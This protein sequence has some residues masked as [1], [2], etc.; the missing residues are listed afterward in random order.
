MAGS[1][2]KP[3]RIS[4][5]GKIEAEEDPLVELARIVSEDGGF[6]TPKPEK[7]RM[8]RNESPQR[9]SY[10]EDLEAE[11]LQELESSLT[12]REPP[13]PIQPRAAAPRPAPASAPRP[14]A[15]QPVRAS[16]GER[17]PD[18][19]LRSIEEQLGQFERR[20]AERVTGGSAGFAAQS[21]QPAAEEPYEE[22][23]SDEAPEEAFDA[24]EEPMPA[25]PSRDTWQS[26]VSR[27]RPLDDDE[28]GGA[29]SEPAWEPEPV[30]VARSDYRFRGPASADWDRPPPAEPP[31]TRV[32]PRTRSVEDLAGFGSDEPSDPDLFAGKRTT[33]ARDLF[34]DDNDLRETEERFPSEGAHRRRIAD[35]FPEFDDE[36][37]S[38]PSASDER[39]AINARLAEALESD[40]AD[41]SHAP[42][43]KAGDVDEGGDEPKVAAAVAAG[44]SR[45]AAAARA[46]AAQRS[47]GARTVLLTAVAVVL[48]VLIGGAAA[49]YLRSIERGPAEPPPVIA[50]DE[51]PVKVEPP[52]DQAAAGGETAGEAVYNRVAGNAPAADEQVVDSAEEPREVAR[53]V[54]PQSQADGADAI[55]RPVGE[56]PAAPDAASA[57]APTDEIGPRRVPTYTVRPDGTIVANSTPETPDAT[58]PAEQQVA[59]AETATTLT[60][61]LPTADEAIGA[62]PEQPMT[63]RPAIEEPQVAAVAPPQ[64]AA[65]TP[66]GQASA[67]PADS[68]VNLLT[69]ANAPAAAAPAAALTDGY[70]VQISS[71]RSMEQAQASYA[72]IQQRYPS[73]LGNLAPVIQEA[74]LGAKG[75]YYRVRVGPW[76]AR[77]EAIQV[78]ESLKSAGGNCFV[79]Q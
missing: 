58:P 64:P 76:S 4:D 17:D 18:D 5:R 56:E 34:G 62:A 1:E 30:P 59:S 53:I 20:Q 60:A 71:Q 74:D 12:G 49:L 14:A 23:A 39:A 69:G 65:E 28:D 8:T 29:P 72:D 43:W 37:L 79:T 55:V 19:L 25:A 7:P 27:L 10:A 41:P 45:R 31:V 48:V 22:P 38:A 42:G 6:S 26:P 21:H 77:D 68:P 15:S 3:G 44:A 73:V 40:Y 78:C 52:Q 66:A 67:A 9:S 50:A 47:K 32:E 13:A 24:A 16:I 2:A 63:P 46:Q 51:A 57:A 54:L 11:L 36:P 33:R 75:I 70:L 35:A 61:D